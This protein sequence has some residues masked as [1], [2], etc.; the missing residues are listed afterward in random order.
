[1]IICNKDIKIYFYNNYKKKRDKEG[2]KVQ[3][4][5]PKIKN[6]NDMILMI[7]KKRKGK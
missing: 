6:K 2:K 4:G 3:R 5:I 7:L 1:M